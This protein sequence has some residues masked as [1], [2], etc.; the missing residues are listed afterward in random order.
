MKKSLLILAL[1][2][3]AVSAGAQVSLGPE[4]GLNQ[5][6]LKIVYP[7]VAF[8]NHLKTG[9]R[10]G[11]NVTTP[12]DRNWDIQTGLFFYTKGSNIAAN[13]HSD[14]YASTMTIGAM[15]LPLYFNLNARP[16]KYG[17]AFAGIGLFMDYHIFCKEEIGTKEYELVIGESTYDDLKHLDAGFGLQAGYLI[18]NGIGFR[19][20]YQLGIANISP[21]VNQTMNSRSFCVSATYLFKTH[22][23]TAAKK[24]R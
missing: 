3:A 8:N 14:Y 20:Q 15:Q 5:S 4:I 21:V 24:H 2:T 9:F 22:P 19:M 7:D 23:A 11:L 6:N 17:K 13:R 18:H 16:G 10:L 1:S 12:L